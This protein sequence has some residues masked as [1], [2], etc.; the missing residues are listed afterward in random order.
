MTGWAVFA[1]VIL[2][3]AG[4]FS[5]LFGLSGL[6]NHDVVTVGGRGV[7]IWSFTAWGWIHLIGGG[8]MIIAGVGLIRD[9]QWARWAAVAFAT[10]N[11]ITQVGLITAAPLLAIL[12][13]ALDVLVIYHLTTQGIDA[14][15]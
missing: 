15:A 7:I 2:F 4:S 6:L 11:A 5:M 3:I 12:I 10:I 1:A 13:I 8:L 14:P 9:R